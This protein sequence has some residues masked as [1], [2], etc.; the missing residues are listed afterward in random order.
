MNSNSLEEI[1]RQ[2]PFLG[3]FEPD[4]ETFHYYF[5]DAAENTVIIWVPLEEAFYIPLNP[6]TILHL[7]LYVPIRGTH[8]DWGEIIQIDSMDK[9]QGFLF[10]VQ[11]GPGSQLEKSPPLD[12]WTHLLQRRSEKKA[13]DLIKHLWI[14]KK[15]I[16]VYT[17]HLSIYF[18]RTVGYYFGRYSEFALF[19]FDDIL[20][21]LD[22]KLNQIASV[23]GTLKG[24]NSEE[25][26]IHQLDFD[27]L[28]EFA[29][30][31]ILVSVLDQALVSVPNHFHKSYMDSIKQLEGQLFFG[32]NQLVLT[33]EQLRAERILQNETQ[34]LALRPSL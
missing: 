23:Y 33:R 8:V 6:G 24:L 5:Y 9:Q 14:V 7:H 29:Q 2:G 12:A 11:I 30:S 18:S 27:W 22:Q 16:L 4:Y 32:F 17:Q 3:R 1:R 34:K 21:K 15:G 25:E 28:M 19:F 31:E 10:K 20:K 26:R 13:L